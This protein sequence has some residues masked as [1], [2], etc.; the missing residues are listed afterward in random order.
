MR[1]TI[2]LKRIWITLS[3]FALAACDRPAPPCDVRYPAPPEGASEVVHVAASCAGDRADGS[4]EHP[5]ATIGAAM[6]H[7]G[8]GA[9]IL[10]APGDYRENL[11][12]R[13]PVSIMGSDDGGDPSAAAVVLLPTG[14]HPVL[15]EGAEGV[16]LQGLV[17]RGGKGA[18]VWASAASVTLKGSR[19]LD[20]V[21][22]RDG[23]PGHGLYASDDAAI[24]LQNNR[25]SGNAGAGVLARRSG[26]VRI[27]G[28]EIFDNGGGGIR[29]ESA[30]GDAH[31]E[32]NAI[33]EN[34]G[35]GVC[36]ASSVA[37]IVQDNQITNTRPLPGDDA[38]GGDGIVVVELR[39]ER[40]ES[41]GPAEAHVEN[42]TIAG[43]A[44]TGILCSG[45]AMAYIVQ[46]EISSNGLSA[47]QSGRFGAG[48]WL[49]RGAGAGGEGTPSSSIDP[50][51]GVV[52]RD[53]E[54]SANAFVAVGAKGGS[55]VFASGNTI[56]SV[57]G[58]TIAGDRGR[59]AIGD[60]IGIF[61]GAS[62]HAT[63][64]LIEHCRRSGLFMDSPA[65][66][67]VAVRDNVLTDY[68]EAAIILQKAGVPPPD[69]TANGFDGT[70]DVRIVA[71]GTC[72]FLAPDLR[73]AL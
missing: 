13:Q 19:I 25:I 63:G 17:I 50:R 68:G 5:Y 54:L 41:L 40:G 21:P 53:N 37:Y 62:I 60:G 22:G 67:L 34:A 16:L 3:A 46:N 44:R 6:S 64:N 59:T 45:E 31:I 11:I 14:D 23:V 49:Q 55:A 61:D 58:A 48:V 1:A 15:V 72:P 70:D 56:R 30:I 4:A 32:E 9:A 12:I 10:T 69:V 66:S 29:L 2:Q 26:A 65:S 7:A 71:A 28:N 43:N 27:A 39:D 57:A 18:A 52:L 42:G 73:P 8:P 33:R 24:I 36:V 51:D 35:A 38:A 47:A 20:T